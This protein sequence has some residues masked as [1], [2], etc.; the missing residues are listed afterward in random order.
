MAAGASRDDLRILFA[1]SC[2]SVTD[3]YVHDK[4]RRL[5]QVADNV[6]LF[7]RKQPQTVTHSQPIPQDEGEGVSPEFPQT[8]ESSV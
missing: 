6:V 8:G 5:D 3:R 2:S 1:H 7:M 4:G